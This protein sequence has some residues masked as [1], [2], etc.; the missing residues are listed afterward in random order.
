MP[1]WIVDPPAALAT[2]ETNAYFTYVSTL[3]VEVRPRPHEHTGDTPPSEP[4]SHVRKRLVLVRVFTTM[5]STIPSNPVER[6]TFA[7]FLQPC[8]SYG[9]V[10]KG[11]RTL[12]SP[13][14]PGS[15]LLYHAAASLQSVRAT[16]PVATTARCGYNSIAQ[17]R[18]RGTWPDSPLLVVQRPR[19]EIGVGSVG[20]HQSCSC[21]L[22]DK[23]YPCSSMH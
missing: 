3:P 23:F 10:R 19:G 11:E 20:S 21:S 15:Y 13:L 5:E 9:A 4:E 2:E 16:G 8:L 17:S 12:L 18:P 14:P 6:A 7:F 22:A 1:P